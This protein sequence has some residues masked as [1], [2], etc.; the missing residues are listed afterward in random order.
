MQVI[1]TALAGRKITKN[2]ACSHLGCMTQ[3]ERA[4]IPRRLVE[5]NLPRSLQVGTH[6]LPRKRN[7]PS[8]DGQLTQTL[9]MANEEGRH[10]RLQATNS[11]IATLPT[12]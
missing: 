6:R 9:A 8:E 4:T 11:I 2:A 5:E 3:A 12:R 10:R 7:R 1:R